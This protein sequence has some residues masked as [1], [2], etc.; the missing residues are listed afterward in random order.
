MNDS[1]TRLMRSRRNRSISLGVC[2]LAVSGI[3]R[4][5][6]ANSIASTLLYARAIGDSTSASLPLFSIR[7]AHV[8]DAR[9]ARRRATRAGTRRRTAARSPTN[10]NSS[11]VTN[12]RRIERRS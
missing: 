10:A 2:M 1:T 11:E 4:P 5:I 9:V 8:V 6:V 3:A 7:P 12:A